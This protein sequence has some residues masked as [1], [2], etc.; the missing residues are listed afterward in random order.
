MSSRGISMVWMSAGRAAVARAAGT[1]KVPAPRVAAGREPG[2]TSSALRRSMTTQ[3]PASRAASHPAAVMNRVS[4]DLISRPY[5]VEAP[6]TVGSPPRS[7][8]L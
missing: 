2:S 6:V 7:R 1:A 3:M 8:A 5:R 4:A